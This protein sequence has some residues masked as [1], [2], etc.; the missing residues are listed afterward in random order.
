MSLDPIER[1]DHRTVLHY[2]VLSGNI[3]IVRLLLHHGANVRFPAEFQ[4]P[5]PLDFAILRGNIEMVKLLIDS[6]SDVITFSHVHKLKNHASNKRKPL[7]MICIKSQNKFTFKLKLNAFQ[8]EM[9]PDLIS[10]VRN[11]A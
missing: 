4:K 5:T 11:C 9:K 1:H 7:T 6:G 3:D 10:L 8:L 2:A